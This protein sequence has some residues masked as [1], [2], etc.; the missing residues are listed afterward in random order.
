[1]SM[2]QSAAV[3]GRFFHL[4]AT[5]GFVASAL[6]RLASFT[7][8]APR[9]DV[10]LV[11]TLFAAMFVPLAAM[12]VRMR[13]ALRPR[14]QWGRV[15]IHD[16]RPLFGAVP[17]G[18]R[19]LMLAAF[20]YMLMNLGLCL[21]LLG[22]ARQVRESGGRYQL[23]ELDGPTRE[24]SREAYEAHRA[25]ETRLYSGHLLFFHLVPMV[26]F[27]FVDR[28]RFALPSSALAGPSP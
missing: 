8:L 12:L 25:V 23:T 19:L 11:L 26:Y 21:L 20:A 9:L 22:G 14:R 27:R 2:R 18:A 16:W 6:L 3:A 28:R 10:G 5:L 24:I 1:M 15:G 13:S 17:P 4:L 7:A